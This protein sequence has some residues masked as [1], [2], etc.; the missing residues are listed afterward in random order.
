MGTADDWIGSTDKPTK[1]QGAGGSEGRTSS[2]G[3]QGVFC[4]VRDPQ[5]GGL[6][7]GAP[8]KIA[9]PKPLGRLVQGN[10]NDTTH[11][12]WVP[13]FETSPFLSTHFPSWILLAFWYD[14]F[15][16]SQK[17]GLEKCTPLWFLL[18]GDST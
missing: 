13:Y 12:C 1:E 16:G 14:L 11:F 17:G 7:R 9:P 6:K 10:Q 15:T 3:E 4:V 5:N 8:S 2:H 18:E